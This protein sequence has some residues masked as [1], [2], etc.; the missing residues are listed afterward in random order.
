LYTSL[1]FCV[2]HSIRYVRLK[3][4]NSVGE[5]SG[6][7]PLDKDYYVDPNKFKNLLMSLSKILE[8]DS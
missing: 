4:E 8:I 5:I 1:I 3:G 6:P 2:H 7:H